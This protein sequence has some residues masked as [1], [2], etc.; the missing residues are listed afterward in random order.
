MRFRLLLI[1][2]G[3]VLV[4]L[5]FSFPFW[6]ELIERDQANEPQQVFPGLSANQQDL[7]LSLPP[8]QQSAYR[9]VAEQDRVK[10]VAMIEGALLPAVP[11]PE[12][13]QEMPAMTG[14]ET[15][16]TGTFTRIDA[17]RWAQGDVTIYQ[18]VDNSKILRFEN[19]SA[20]NAPA[21]RVALALTPVE[22]A[23]EEGEEPPGPIDHILADGLDLGPLI[24][25]SGSQNYEIAP[26][27]DIGQFDSVV[28][29][30]PTLEMIF[31]I[32]PLRS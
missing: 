29:Y 23:L 22:E 1:T 2:L 32:A 9:A 8:E 30:S 24:G 15:I 31:S 10:A 7:F 18:Q 28:I 4:A 16:R 19:F 5:T 27:I 12:D 13:Q 20:V 6:L 3:A 26:E 17:I 14:A 11:A 21:L 25:T